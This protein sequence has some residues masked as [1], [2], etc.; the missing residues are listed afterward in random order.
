MIVPQH[1]SLEL[2]VVTTVF[3]SE[4]SIDEFYERAI[5]AA[6]ALT[7]SYEVVFVDDGSPDSS[8]ARVLRIATRDP[9]VVLVELSRNFGHHRALFAGLAESR[10]R[11]VF[12]IDSDLQEDP[13]W[14]S[15]F[16]AEMHAGN[17]APDVVYGVD[18][19]RRGSLPKRALRGLFY[20][21]FNSLSDTKIPVNATT[22]RLMSREYVGALLTVGDQDPF[23]A[24]SFVWTGFRQRAIEVEK[25]SSR[26]ESSYGPGRLVAMA[27]GSVTS[28]SSYPLKLISLS[29]LAIAA[30]AGVFGLRVIV[31]KLLDPESVV[32]GYSSVIVSIWLMGG[33]LLFSVGVVGYYLSRVFLEVKNRPR[34]IVRQVH[35]KSE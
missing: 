23:L 27:L 30:V 11:L 33:L 2:S 14:L 1:G 15:R 5:G 28:F 10:G 7:D 17:A 13:E 12:L 19:S 6:M 22:A 20:R 18:K 9:R 8:A 32:L 24:A 21:V 16:W 29:G 35:R 26:R 25:S 34:F 3:R 31:I 4:D